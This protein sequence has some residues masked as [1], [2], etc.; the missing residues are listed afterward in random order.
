MH[1]EPQKEHRWLNKLVG[2]WTYEFEGTMGPDQPPMKSQGVEVVRL[3]GD[4]WT[5]GESEGT[6]P[7]G[8]VSKNV[9]TLG[10]DPAAGRY[11]GTFV[12]SSMP[13]LWIY[14]GTLDESGKVLALDAEGPSFTGAGTAQYRDSIEIIDDNYRVMT[15][16]VLGENGEW[17]EFMTAH[18]RRKS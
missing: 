6:S 9:M 8:S 15:S 2:E 5:I 17:H 11:V 10:Y 7:G 4:L 3:F 13:F 16:R 18:Y 12:A 1:A 14:S